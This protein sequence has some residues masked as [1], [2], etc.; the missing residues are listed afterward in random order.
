MGSSS[1][2]IRQNSRMP[3]AGAQSIRRQSTDVIALVLPMRTDSPGWLQMRFVLAVL[4]AAR[5][6]G[7][8]LMLLTAEDGVAAISDVVDRAMVDG[9]IVM[10][11]EMDDPRIPLL[12]EI[13]RPSVL[14]GT[15][16]EP[17][18]FVHVDFDF[19]AAGALCVDHLHHLGH[20]HIGY[21][22]HSQQ[23][24]DREVGYAL[25]AR[26]GVLDALAGH[27]LRQTWA[28]MDPTHTGAAAALESTIAQDPDLTAL[29]VYNELAFLPVLD[30]LTQLGR[31]VPRDLSI[32]TI[33]QDDLG[34]PRGFK[35]T[36]IP[37]PAAELGRAAFE[38]LTGIIGK[39]EQPVTTLL[40]P[41]L[42]RQGS[43][44]SPGLPPVPDCHRDSRP[45]AD[46]RCP[47]PM[48]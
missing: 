40:E 31:S 37:I 32:I 23:I 17:T 27:G 36:N 12:G 33:G 47:K 15:P 20:R 7:M 6:R 3:H 42:D 30:R 14:I 45:L 43:T 24:Y 29:I 41:R 18:D 38:R 5:E 39:H 21:L 1:S 26:R 10:D 2:L 9:V 35:P 16:R 28:A 8:H 22:G 44:S 19:T 13:N 11:I 4:D 48:L 46:T 25:R 34:A